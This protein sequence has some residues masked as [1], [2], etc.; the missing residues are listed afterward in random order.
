MRDENNVPVNHTMTLDDTNMLNNFDENEIEF[1]GE[2]KKI[3]I[4]KAQTIHLNLAM[5]KI[6]Y[7]TKPLKFKI[8]IN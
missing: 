4:I 1:D 6:F 3:R 7:I 2:Q 5:I 8:C